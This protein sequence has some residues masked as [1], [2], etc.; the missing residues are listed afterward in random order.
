MT[1]V[2]FGG[3]TKPPD[4]RARQPSR[5]RVLITATAAP[6]PS[7]TYGETVCVAGPRL[8][9]GHEGWVR[10]YP[11]NLRFIEQDH[12]SASTTL[13]SLDAT[14]ATEGRYGSW[15]PRMLGVR[16]KAASSRPWVA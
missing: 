6:N 16:R 12:A 13:V 14:P 11:I 1:D 7:A 3:P 2:L 5:L 15:K 8:D 10:L 4:D 9:A